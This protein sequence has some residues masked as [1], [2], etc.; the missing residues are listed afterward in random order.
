M[1]CRQIAGLLLGSGRQSEWPL[2]CELGYGIIRSR[3]LL[4]RHR[5]CVPTMISSES[6]AAPPSDNRRSWLLAIVACT[7]GLLTALLGLVLVGVGMGFANATASGTGMAAVFVG[8][9][10]SL[11][12]RG[13][14]R[15]RRVTY[16]GL[17]LGWL[18]LLIRFVWDWPAT[19][20]SGIVVLFLVPAL[21]VPLVAIWL[22]LV[23]VAGFAG[24]VRSWRMIPH[25]RQLPPSR[26]PCDRAGERGEA[27]G[28]R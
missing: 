28:R 8:L 1:D 26:G 13:I 23:T 5:F 19:A 4:L 11:A 9:W 7:T 17:S 12:G 6:P 21:S 27:T 22:V 16:L 18:W 15:C 14:S 2:R 24:A 20:A 25:K 10:T 3:L